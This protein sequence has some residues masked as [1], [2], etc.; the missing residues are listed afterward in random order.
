MYLLADDDREVRLVRPA[1]LADEFL[2]GEPTTPLDSGSPVT[3]VVRKAEPLVFRSRGELLGRYPQMEGRVRETH[4]A[5]AILPIQL[6]GPALGSLVVSFN[7]PRDFGEA[8]LAFLVAL[9]QQAAQALERAALYEG[10][11]QAREEAEA[12]T[13]RLMHLEAISKA[14]LTHLDL[15]DLLQELLQRIKEIASADRAVILLKEDDELMV[16]AAIGVEEEVAAGV[17]V[18]IGRGIAGTIAATAKPLV[19]EDMSTVQ[20]VS[21]YLRERA[22]SLAGVPLLIDGEVIGV[23]HVSTDEPRRFAVEEIAILEMVAARAALAINQARVFEREH[24][25]S[26]TLQRSLLPDSLPEIPGLEVAARYIPSGRG[27]DVGGDWFDAIELSGGRVALVVGDVVGH[28]LRAAAVMGQLRS[29]LRAYAVEGHGPG[30]ILERV[31]RMTPEPDREVIATALCLFLD[32][33]SGEVVYASAGHPPP[34]VVAPGGHARFLEGA[35][36]VPL[37][38]V[39]GA[40][41]PEAADHLSPGSAILLYTDGL[42]ESRELSIDEGLGRLRDAASGAEGRADRIADH[43]LSTMLANREPGDDVALLV[44]RIAGRTATD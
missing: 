8:D 25:I 10:E 21:A 5:W 40:R 39:D 27:L 38:A 41:F 37:G 28:G 42:V 31:D 3:D 20:P 17:R 35:R 32:P 36:S 18:P 30:I 4:A 29:A 11:R 19:V 15:D 33:G 7:E 1:G 26:E 44:V 16:R 22:R 13:Q 9:A 12:A 6:T 2:E 14:G 43:V 24:R 34:L 23:L